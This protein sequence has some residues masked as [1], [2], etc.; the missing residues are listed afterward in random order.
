MEH[1]CERANTVLVEDIM[2][3]DLV[4]RHA[5]HAPHGNSRYHDQ[6]TYPQTAR[7]ERREDRGHGVPLGSLLSPGATIGPR[8]GRR[9]VLQ[10]R[11]EDS[12]QERKKEP[13]WEMYQ[14]EKQ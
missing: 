9:R 6:E 10:L 5:R 2:T 4:T 3:T 7:C 12:W 1:V 14:Y 11:E 8:A 13:S